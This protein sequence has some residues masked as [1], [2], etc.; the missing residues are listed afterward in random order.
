M[1]QNRQPAVWVTLCAFIW[2]VRRLPHA[3]ALKFAGLLGAWVPLFTR[4]KTRE[5]SLRCAKILGVSYEE[6]YKITTGAY[7]H[8]AKAAAEFAR[9]PV[10]VSRIKE[11]VRVHGEDNLRSAM[12]RGK[13]VILATAHLGNW[14]YAAAWCAQSGYPINGLGTDQRDDRITKLIID[15]RSSGGTKALGKATDLK[16]MFRALTA[17]EIIAVPIDQDAKLNGVVSPFLGFPASTP[18]GVAKLA[19]KYGCAV[20]PAFCVRA[21]DGVTMD[22]H[23][24]PAMQGRG[25]R[26]YGEDIQ[27]S[28][29]DC[30]AVISKWIK[31]YPDQWM[32]LY[33]RWESVERGMFGEVRDRPGQV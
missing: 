5:S 22:F 14:E 16:A 17:G 29:D 28:M 6:A 30:N 21:A 33:P 15:L 3:A 27:T 7:R 11:L 23:F 2:I 18:T 12:D 24:L 9:L 8:F 10:M 25:G 26:P 19:G 4:K 1:P 31:A 13:G 20:L 32:W